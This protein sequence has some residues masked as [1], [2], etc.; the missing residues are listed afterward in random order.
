MILYFDN[1]IKYNIFNFYNIAST[2][3]LKKFNLLGFSI[4]MNN[5]IGIKPLIAGFCNR[6]VVIKCLNRKDKK[7]ALLAEIFY[8]GTIFLCDKNFI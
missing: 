2:F 3:I 5:G 8:I 6:L 7:F 4:H 1:I